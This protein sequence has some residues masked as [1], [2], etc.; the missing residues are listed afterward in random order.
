MKRQDIM[1]IIPIYANISEL[2]N[3][4]FSIFS[5]CINLISKTNQ[6]MHEIVVM[7]THL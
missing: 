7:Q 2:D 5:F 6:R 1:P 4:N 3:F